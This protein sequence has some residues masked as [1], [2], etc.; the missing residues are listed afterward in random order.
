MSGR[1]GGRERGGREEREGD[2][3][4]GERKELGGGGGGGG[5]AGGILLF[6]LQVV[7]GPATSPTAWI[8]KAPLSP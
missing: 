1:E 7:S 5:E 8:T 2:G 3:G 4:K 6:T